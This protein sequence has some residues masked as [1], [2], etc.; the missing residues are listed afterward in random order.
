M[1]G[2]SALFAGRFFLQGAQVGVLF[3]F[4]DQRHDDIALAAALQFRL[5]AAGRNRGGRRRR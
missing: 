2:Q 3:R 1:P 4:F 5:A